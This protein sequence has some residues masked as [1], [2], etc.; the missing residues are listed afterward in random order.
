MA[1]SENLE[2]LLD[3][4]NAVEI[5]I[6]DIR[7]IEIS[8]L[9]AFV[10]CCEENDL[11][12]TLAGGTLLGA[13]RH[14]GF[15]PWD[16]DIDVLMPR[17]DYEKFLDITQGI[18][19]PYVVRSI[20]THPELHTRPFARVVCNGYMTEL[21]TP[22][23]K[24]PPWIDVFPMDGMPA[25]YTA[26]KIYFKVLK[27]LKT[28]IGL[29]WQHEKRPLQKTEKNTTKSGKYKL[30]YLFKMR[31][32]APILA[33]IFRVIGHHKLLMLLQK[34]A[35]TMHY[36]TCEYVGCVVAGGHGIRERMPKQEFEDMIK[37]PFEGSEYY[38]PGCYELYLSNLY[39][40]NYMELPPENQRQV[41]IVK[42]W[43]EI[44]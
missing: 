26:C 44:T 20:E 21:C 22:P 16:D 25:N 36:E 18:L 38:S 35:K 33:K 42:C 13:I 40:S 7:F 6:E 43:K 11:K 31:V 8:I 5:N 37:V 15:I 34:T 19:G 10:K 27:K 17:P 23:Y 9:N 12:Y 2:K 24:L 41:H 32:L 3:S 30:R 39:G 29:S 1:W 28:I 14:S 4:N